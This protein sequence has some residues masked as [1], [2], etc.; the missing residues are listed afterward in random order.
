MGSLVCSVG[1]IRV[2]CVILLLGLWLIGLSTELTADVVLSRDTEFGWVT[3]G[4]Y[5][6]GG[7]PG[8]PADAACPP[9]LELT[10]TASA[11]AVAS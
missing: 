9:C 4:C 5:V 6:V 10:A 8:L 7:P 1:L 11:I 2:C 3:W